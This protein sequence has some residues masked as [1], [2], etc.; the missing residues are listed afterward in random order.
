MSYAGVFSKVSNKVK[1]IGAP[2]YNHAP[3]YGSNGNLQGIMHF[4]YRGA[5]LSGPTLHEILHNWANKFRKS[6]Y[7]YKVGSGSHW[8]YTG[9]CGGKGQIGG[10]D[11]NTFRDENLTDKLNDQKKIFSAAYFGWNANGGKVSPTT[12]SNSI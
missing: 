6:S 5:I 11:A 9:F 8:G 7:P 3:L 1:G 12:M 4:A 10:Y 2:L